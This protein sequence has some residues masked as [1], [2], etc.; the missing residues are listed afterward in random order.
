MNAP[1]ISQMEIDKWKD[2]YSYVVKI[3][4]ELLDHSKSIGYY[5]APDVH[6]I[7]KCLNLLKQDNIGEAREFLAQNTWLGGDIDQ[8]IKES[9]AIPAQATLWTMT[10][11]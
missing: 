4:I 8:Q 10:D 3:T 11:I 9:Y 7:T 2:K 5:K 6:I 1:L